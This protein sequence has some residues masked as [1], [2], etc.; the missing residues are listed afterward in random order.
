MLSKYTAVLVPVGVV[1]AFAGAP[2]LRRQLRRPGP[3]IACLVGALMFLPVFLWNASHDWISFRFQLRHGLHTS[4]GSA[5]AN[6]IN[7][8]GGQVG[9]VS[10]ILFALAL[11]AVFAALR[12]PAQP[13]RYVLAVVAAMIWAFFAYTALRRAVEPNWPALAL[14]PAV[15]LLATWPAAPRWRTWERAGIAL[16]GAMVVGIYVQAVYPWLPLPRRSDPI[17]QAYGWED[18]ARA[19]TLT[20]RETDPPGRRIWLAADRYQDAAELAFHLAGHPTVFSLNLGGRSNQYDLWPTARDSLRLGDGLTVVLDDVDGTP[21]PAAKLAPHFARV[22]RG[23]RVE[24]RRRGQVVARRRL[25][26]FLDLRVP[27]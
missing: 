23:T 12:R 24:M 7:L 15:L 6:E 19:V 4:V 10:P 2:G 20:G 25:W 17:A 22:D 21:P 3:Y 8:I 1:L 11:A 18:L 5:L 13:R 26:H 16:A 14:V 27:L 9:L